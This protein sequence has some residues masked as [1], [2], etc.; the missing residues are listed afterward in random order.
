MGLTVWGIAIE[1]ARFEPREV[2]MSRLSRWSPLCALAL[3]ALAGCE[4]GTEHFLSCQFDP[5]LAEEDFLRCTSAI[6]GVSTDS[7]SCIVAKHPQCPEDVCLSWAGSDPFCSMS[8]TDD[9]SCPAG[10]VCRTYELGQ[11]EGEPVRYC[12]R[13]A[14]LPCFVNADCPGTACVG[15]DEDD[16]VSGRCAAP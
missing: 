6:E 1:C 16:G 7:E 8:C 2:M 4:G 12:I 9:A 14:A 10:S 13:A 11:T 3:A 15:A 5:L